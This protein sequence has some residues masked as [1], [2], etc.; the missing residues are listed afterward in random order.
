MYTHY[1]QAK[2]PPEKVVCYATGKIFCKDC[3]RFNMVSMCLVVFFIVY[4]V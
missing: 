3:C 4:V 2:G 1:L